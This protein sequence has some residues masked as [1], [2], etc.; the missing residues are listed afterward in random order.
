MPRTQTRSSAR[1]QGLDTTSEMEKAMSQLRQRVG[2]SSEDVLRAFMNADMLLPGSVHSVPKDYPKYPPH[3]IGLGKCCFRAVWNLSRVAATQLFR[4]MNDGEFHTENVEKARE[5]IS[6][7]LDHATVFCLRRH[8]GDKHYVAIKLCEDGHFV[9]YD[10]HRYFMGNP[11]CYEFACNILQL[12]QDTSPSEFG[13][14]TS[15]M[16]SKDFDEMKK[17]FGS[18]SGSPTKRPREDTPEFQALKPMTVRGRMLLTADRPSP[19][20]KRQKQRKKQK[21]ETP[22]KQE[23]LT[24]SIEVLHAQRRNERPGTVLMTVQGDHLVEPVG[25]RPPF[26]PYDIM[27]PEFAKPEKSEKFLLM[28]SF[29]AHAMKRGREES[30]GLTVLCSPLAKCVDLGPKADMRLVS[31]SET[32]ATII[33]CPQPSSCPC[34][35]E[36]GS[37]LFGT[38]QGEEK[39]RINDQHQMILLAHGPSINSH[40]SLTAHLVDS[41]VFLTEHDVVSGVLFECDATVNDMFVK[42]REMSSPPYRGCGGT[43]KY[44]RALVQAAIKLRLAAFLPIRGEGIKIQKERWKGGEPPD[45]VEHE[46][47]LCRKIS[48]HARSSSAAGQLRQLIGNRDEVEVTWNWSHLVSFKKSEKSIFDP[49]AIQSMIRRVPSTDW[50]GFCVRDYIHRIHEG[51]VTNSQGKYSHD[52][53]GAI[54]TSIEMVAVEDVYICPI[55]E[56]GGCGSRRHIKLVCGCCGIP[57]HTEEIEFDSMEK[58]FEATPQMAI[59]H[60]LMAN[61]AEDHTGESSPMI[62]IGDV[63]TRLEKK[64]LSSSSFRVKGVTNCRPDK[65]CPDSCMGGVKRILGAIGC[66][67]DLGDKRW[68]QIRLS[69]DIFDHYFVGIGGC[70]GSSALNNYAWYDDSPTEVPFQDQDQDVTIMEPYQPPE[71]ANKIEEGMTVLLLDNANGLLKFNWQDE[72]LAQ[73]EL[74]ESLPFLTDKDNRHVQNMVT[75]QGSSVRTLQQ[76]GCLGLYMRQAG[77]DCDTVKKYAWVPKVV[78]PFAF[79]CS[80]GCED[81][82]TQKGRSKKVSPV[83]FV[84]QSIVAREE[85][86]PE[87]DEIVAWDDSI[88]RLDSKP[89]DDAYVIN[90][91]P[92]LNIVGSQYGILH[93]WAGL[94]DVVHGEFTPLPARAKK[95]LSSSAIARRNE[96][97]EIMTLLSLHP[98]RVKIEGPGNRTEVVGLPATQFFVSRAYLQGSPKHI[99]MLDKLTNPCFHGQPLQI[100]ILGCSTGSD[101]RSPPGCGPALLPARVESGLWN[102]YTANTRNVLRMTGQDL[103]PGA[104]EAFRKLQLDMKNVP[105]KELLPG[106]KNFWHKSGNGIIPGPEEMT[107][108]Q[109]SV[110]MNVVGLPTFVVVK[111]KVG[112]TTYEHLIGICPVMEFCGD[113]KEGWTPF[114]S[115]GPNDNK[116]IRLRIID[117]QHPNLEAF[118]FNR[119]NLDWCCGPEGFSTACSAFSIFPLKKLSSAVVNA[120]CLNLDDNWYPNMIELSN[121]GVSIAME[122]DKTTPW[123]FVYVNVVQGRTMEEI[124]SAANAEVKNIDGKSVAYSNEQVAMEHY[125]LQYNKEYFAL[126]SDVT[127][128]EWPLTGFPRDQIEDR[129]AQCERE[130]AR[131]YDIHRGQVRPSDVQAAEHLKSRAPAYV[132]RMF[133]LIVP[134]E[135]VQRGQVKFGH[136]YMRALQDKV[137]FM[138]VK[139]GWKMPPTWLMYLFQARVLHWMNDTYYPSVEKFSSLA[140]ATLPDFKEVDGTECGAKEPTEPDFM[141]LDKDDDSPWLDV[142]TPQESYQAPSPPPSK[143]PS[144]QNIQCKVEEIAECDDGTNSLDFYYYYIQ[145]DFGWNTIP[146]NLKDPIRKR[147][148]AVRREWVEPGELQE[149]LHEVDKIMLSFG[150][151]AFHSGQYNLEDF[152]QRLSRWFLW[153]LP[154]PN[155]IK[156]IVKQ[157]VKD[158][159]DGNAT[160]GDSNTWD[161]LV[162]Q[163]DPSDLQIRGIIGVA[164]EQ[165]RDRIRGGEVKLSDFWRFICDDESCRKDGCSLTYPPNARVKMLVRQ[166]L[167]SLLEGKDSPRKAL[168]EWVEETGGLPGLLG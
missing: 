10:E 27:D 103:V 76:L 132:R 60:R 69:K 118:A 39:F 121:R 6:K 166:E 78:L 135:L 126:P 154:L 159:M 104:E 7:Y 88:Q 11:G 134:H 46:T 12:I 149:I 70:Q 115:E 28:A 37:V 49:A 87:Y 30:R 92:N 139:V 72:S 26:N 129:I 57:M 148:A 109:L 40:S 84:L 71:S 59:A 18:S 74:P 145:R 110:Y 96:Q 42:H 67:R 58:A 32:S 19:S 79:S 161:K 123:P 150:R 3:M 94:H 146:E 48:P 82:Y 43:G 137:S 165:F 22:R 116:K 41:S 130:S 164:Y 106:L 102:C 105:N 151:E 73:Q 68:R 167:A 63:P 25:F 81:I 168:R 36:L 142:A 35:E 29:M 131:L 125:W 61:L 53:L 108:D 162:E 100:H 114:F 21:R 160:E 56:S 8:T 31:F 128:G 75:Q 144:M 20:R 98:F 4:M 5:V 54:S 64:D 15:S 90:W 86:K 101:K 1:V 45:V 62:S 155:R 80:N 24:D 34:F 157:R 143:M 133:Q 120:L 89:G 33:Y 158:L 23:V 91:V 50:N 93:N 152:Y 38:H 119:E 14:L 2:D 13:G 117:G 156:K 127:L 97:P 66:E 9:Y 141:G 113:K 111:V 51:A 85:W 77:S 153:K 16:T 52:S 83:V 55:V 163:S 124:R 147:I 107:F 99:K 136:L 65:K 17:R 122:V 44:L 140:D 138:A 47:Y 112:E 95:L